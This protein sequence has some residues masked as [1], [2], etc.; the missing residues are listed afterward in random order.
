MTHV[1]TRYATKL[2]REKGYLPTEDGEAAKGNEPAK[3]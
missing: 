2:M 1:L 3:R